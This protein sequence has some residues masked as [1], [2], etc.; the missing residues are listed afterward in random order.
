MTLTSSGKAKPEHYRTIRYNLELS[1]TPEL[2][3]SSEQRP[4]AVPTDE[5]EGLAHEPQEDPV[6]KQDEHQRLTVNAAAE[7]RSEAIESSSQPET[8]KSWFGWLWRRS[9]PTREQQV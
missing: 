4:A 3:M 1:A 7:A 8:S 6:P 9:G 5:P 2:S